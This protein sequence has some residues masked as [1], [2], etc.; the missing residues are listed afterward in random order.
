MQI[1][2]IGKCEW[3]EQRRTFGAEEIYIKDE[4]K[5][6]ESNGMCVK[7]ESFIKMT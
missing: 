5:I 4:I 2:G 6:Y 3:T 7:H 1:L